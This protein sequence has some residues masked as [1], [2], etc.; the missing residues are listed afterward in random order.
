MGFAGPPEVPSSHL[1]GNGGV[2]VGATDPQNPFGALTLPYAL[3]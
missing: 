1:R 3:H 2:G